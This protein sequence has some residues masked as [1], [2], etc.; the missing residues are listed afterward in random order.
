MKEGQQKD[1]WTWPGEKIM[2]DRQEIRKIL[3]VQGRQEV[4]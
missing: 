1:I 4:P 2:G 3:K